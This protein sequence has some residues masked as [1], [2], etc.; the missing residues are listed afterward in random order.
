[1]YSIS[2]W[3]VFLVSFW[4]NLC[5]F[6]LPKLLRGLLIILPSCLSTWFVRYVFWL[7]Y[8][9]LKSFGFYFIRLLLCF[10]HLLPLVGRIFFLCFGMSCLVYIVVP[11]V[12]ISLIFLLLPGL[13]GSFPQ[14]YCYFLLY[15]LFLFVSTCYSVFPLFYHYGRF[16]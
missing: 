7:P 10:C 14:L 4:V 6:P 3:Y 9:S 8:F 1:M 13:S 11:F 16:S 5:V 15:C 12:D 2:A